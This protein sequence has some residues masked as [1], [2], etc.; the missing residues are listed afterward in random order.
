MCNKYTN[1]GAACL[2]NDDQEDNEETMM[3]DNNESED[4][5]LSPELC[6]AAAK[7]I[8]ALK[9]IDASMM[10]ANGD[11]SGNK[12]STVSSG[13]SGGP[14][15]WRDTASGKY[16]LYGVVSFTTNGTT[17]PPVFQYVPSSLEWIRATT[18]IQQVHNKLETTQDSKSTTTTTSASVQT[19]TKWTDN[20]IFMSVVAVLFVACVFFA[21]VRCATCRNGHKD[22]NE[23]RCEHVPSLPVIHEDVDNYFISVNDQQRLIG[24]K[25]ARL[26]GRINA[27]IDV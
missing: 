27:A 22:S 18:G 26:N 15:L 9:T 3:Y 10:C 5:D 13:D 24:K 16:I 8:P 14:L 2:E 17:L 19:D 6:C 11:G 23:I 4:G 21:I 12:Q 20:Y 7:L 25:S 1:N